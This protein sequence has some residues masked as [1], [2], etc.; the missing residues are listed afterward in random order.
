ML[1]SQVRQKPGKESR[2][3]LIKSSALSLNHHQ[4]HLLLTASNVKSIPHTFATTTLNTDELPIAI[5]QGFLNLLT[6][7]LLSAGGVNVGVGLGDKTA[8]P[9]SRELPQP[10]STLRSLLG[11]SSTYCASINL[12]CSHLTEERILGIIFSSPSRPA[13]PSVNP[14]GVRDFQSLFSPSTH[15]VLSPSDPA[16][17]VAV[18]SS[19]DRSFD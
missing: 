3:L 12:T 14:P 9:V 13:R 7:F 19:L 8:S 4:L 5:V 11:T 17:P 6:V 15:H 18:L 10:R 2:H 1:A 16:K